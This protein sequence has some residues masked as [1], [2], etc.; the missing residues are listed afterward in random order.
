[1]PPQC[2]RNISERL[3]CVYSKIYP[4][5]PASKLAFFPIYFT[6]VPYILVTNPVGF[7]VIL[8]LV[9]IDKDDVVVCSVIFISIYHSSVKLATEGLTTLCMNTL[10]G[11]ILT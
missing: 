9:A 11:T 10:P 2:T 5:T 3:C 4:T 1:M 6:K 7:G 8:L